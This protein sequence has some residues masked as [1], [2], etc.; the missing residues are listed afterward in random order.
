METVDMFHGSKNTS[1]KTLDY[2]Q[3]E[4]ACTV[5]LTEALEAS[6]FTKAHPPAT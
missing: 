6:T 4:E 3:A 5:E 2:T 1:K